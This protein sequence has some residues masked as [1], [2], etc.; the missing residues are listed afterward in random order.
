[1]P[2]LK[3][4]TSLDTQ[5]KKSAIAE[6]AIDIILHSSLDEL[7]IDKVTSSVGI[8]RTLFYHYFKNKDALLEEIVLYIENKLFPDLLIDLRYPK[9]TIQ[10]I[11]RAYLKEIGNNSTVFLVDLSFQIGLR[12]DSI[13]NLKYPAPT[14]LYSLKQSFKE[15][16]NS[17]ELILSLKDSIDTYLMLIYG[18]IKNRIENS[19]P[20]SL[21]A[22]QISKILFKE[23]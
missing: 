12:L 1:M 15:L 11:T 2:R 22:N 7:D 3:I 10:A 19:N 8:G 21:S 13:S 4:Q 16:N 5:N 14:M 23:I 17:G 6:T 9:K 18:Q 20:I